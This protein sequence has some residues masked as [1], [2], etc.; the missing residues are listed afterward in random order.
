MLL[1]K[2]V[3]FNILF[4]SIILGYALSAYSADD[5]GY[6][7]NQIKKIETQL[8]QEREKLKEFNLQ[9]KDLLKEL[10]EFEREVSAK[11]AAINKVKLSITSAKEKVSRLDKELSTVEQSYEKA[12]GILAEKLI[13][14]YKYAKRGF[15]GV[16]ASSRGI[17]DF[18]HRVKYLK[19]IM[20][21]D[22]KV[23]LALAESKDSYK[24]RVSEIKKEA[25]LIEKEKERQN[26]ELIMLKK[27]LEKKVIQLV[28]IH[29]EKEFYETAVRQLG[30]ATRQLGETFQDIEKKKAFI[31]SGDSSFY[32]FKGKL[33]SPV[34]GKA[35]K[36]DTVTEKSEISNLKGVFIES[37]AGSEV[38][39]VFPG[40]VD[41]SGKL[42]GYGEMVIINHGDRFFTVSAQLANRNKHEGDVVEAGDTIGM[43]GNGSKTVRL[44]FDVRKAGKSLDP[45]KWFRSK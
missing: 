21:E 4:T 10:A 17:N 14:L 28:R 24:K 25:A 37:P 33:P 35:I 13:L 43:L 32:D 22:H 6:R 5:G 7:Q 26:A 9:E 40:R 41:F 1:P 16:L 3:F 15:L 20:R 18:W 45:M 44:Y 2:N 23:M 42:K 12:R 29:R 36:C 30:A 27:D 8:L 11:N 31:A 34:E 39:A 19:I 38:R